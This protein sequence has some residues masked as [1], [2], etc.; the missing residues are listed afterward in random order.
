[1]SL[2]SITVKNQDNNKESDS[3]E[4]RRKFY[5]HGVEVNSEKINKEEAGQWEEGVWM[6]EKELGGVLS[7]WESFTVG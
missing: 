3:E 2:G 6:V 7:S 4:I 1:M 5:E